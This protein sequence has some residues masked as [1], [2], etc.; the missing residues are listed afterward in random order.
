LTTQESPRPRLGWKAI[1]PLP[2]RFSC[3]GD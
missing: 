1:F 2:K 3:S